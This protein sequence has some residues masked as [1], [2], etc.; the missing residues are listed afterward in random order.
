MSKIEQHPIYR[1]PTA[2]DALVVATARGIQPVEALEALFRA[3]SERIA[4]EKHDPLRYGWEPSIWRVMDSMLGLD[5]AIPEMFG[6]DYGPRMRKLLG[7]AK[8][9]S[10]GMIN[11]G[12]RGGKTTYMVKRCTQCAHRYDN[13]TMWVFHTDANMSKVYHQTEFWK[14]MPPNLRRTIKTATTYISFSLKSGFSD[15]TEF[16]LPN[17]SR[18]E[19]RTYAMDKNK[20]EG[21]NLGEPGKRGNMVNADGLYEWRCIGFMADEHVPGDWIETLGF[22]IAE[23]ESCGVVGFTPT[24][25]YSEAVKLFRDAAQPVRESTAYLLPKDGGDVDPRLYER[26]DCDAWLEA[27]AK[28]VEVRMFEKIPRVMKCADS[29][30]GILFIH[31]SDN[32]YGNPKEVYG[33]VA[34]KDRRMKL[35]R[36][37]G[38]A[39]KQFGGQFPLFNHKVHVVKHEDIPAEGTNYLIVDPCDGRNFFMAWIRVTPKGQVYVVAEWPSCVDPVP[40]F[41]VLG[42]WA[43]TSGDS[44]LQDGRRGPAQLGL[45]WGLA[46]YKAEIARVEGWDCYKD[47]V[48]PDEIVKWDEHGKAKMKVFRRFLDSRFGNTNSLN[49]DGVRSLFDEFMDCGLTFEETSTGNRVEIE[50]GVRMINDALYYNTEQPVVEILNESRL[51]ISDRCLNMIFALQ[52]WTG[53]D[54]AKA[55]T[56]DPIDCLRYFFLKECG[57]V[58]EKSL[59]GVAGGGCY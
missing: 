21:G 43:V 23:R 10:I 14:F 35:E 1:V 6:K 37:Y 41:G 45:G 56:K 19:F 48:K 34:A 54:G 59:G 7:F 15:G 18:V 26:E 12:Q 9:V 39:T 27:D 24:N 4:N 11:G 29:R 53:A 46:Q 50:T 36:Y 13:T 2:A 16:I 32:P 3:R 57:F 8:P 31:S 42:E 40:G 47:G 33:T 17:G 49:A 30:R 25:G 52:V 20:I 44:K 38:V 28:S 51:F 55:A 5:W 22:R 58:S